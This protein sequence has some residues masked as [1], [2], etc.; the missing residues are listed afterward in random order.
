M[1]IELVCVKDQKLGGQIVL[2]TT[3]FSEAMK[4]GQALSKQLLSM[5]RIKLER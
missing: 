4:T 2:I 3:V 1:V 5:Q